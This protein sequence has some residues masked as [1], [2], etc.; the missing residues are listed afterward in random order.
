M[1]TGD[2][3]ICPKDEQT[4][5]DTRLADLQGYLQRPALYA[6]TSERF[7]NDPY[8]STQMLNAHLDPETDAASRKPEFIRQSADW[9]RSLPLPDRA[10]LL[11]IGCG[12]GLYAK[13]FAERGLRVT[14]VDFSA[15]SLTYA[16]EHD[17]ESDYLL[18]DYLA[19]DFE[20][21]FDI[22]TLIY[23]DYGALIPDERRDLLFRVH[24]ALRPGGLFIFDVF[25]TLYNRGREDSTSWEWNPNGGF[26]SPQPHLCLNAT[27]RYD[28]TAEGRRTVVI[29]ARSVRC[30]NIWDCLF[31]R[32]SLQN[33]TQPAG[34]EEYGLYADVTGKAYADDSQTMCAVLRKQP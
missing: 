10:Q 17:P 21:A 30:F 14:G 31:T 22:V 12:P 1:P 6:R 8:I 9:I 27:Y 28:E 24:R 13:Q 29:D 33:E 26:W 7:W 34:F 18:Q 4:M 20:N 11:D 15:N 23:C 16:R 2:A 32:E 3:K 5:L 19:L 25:T